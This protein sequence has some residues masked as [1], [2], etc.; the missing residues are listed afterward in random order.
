MWLIV[1]GSSGSRVMRIRNIAAM[2]H[3]FTNVTNI[4]VRIGA[5]SDHTLLVNSHFDSF[6]GSPGACFN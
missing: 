1:F 3:V 6:P 5:A 2:S 4:V